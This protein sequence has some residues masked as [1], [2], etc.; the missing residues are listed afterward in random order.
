M[1]G[2][3]NGG[4]IQYMFNSTIIN[5]ANAKFDKRGKN[6]LILVCCLKN[7]RDLAIIKT[8]R[9]ESARMAMCGVNMVTRVIKKAVFTEFLGFGL[10]HKDHA[11]LTANGKI[12]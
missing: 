3:V 6:V 2:S 10:L 12:A 4:I 8:M 5:S 11:D 1:L 9:T 7:E